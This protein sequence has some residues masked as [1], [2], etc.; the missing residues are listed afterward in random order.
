MKKGLV[1]GL[2]GLFL[3]TGCGKKVTCSQTLKEGGEKI[4][5]KVIADVKK[6]KIDSIEVVYNTESKD[7][8]SKFCKVYKDAKCSGK[9]VTLSNK[10]ALNLFGLTEKQLQDTSK[11]DFVK[12]IESTGFKCK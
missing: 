2:A 7:T 6:D 9:K 10:V 1:L 5:A 12:G 8:A 3:L 11:D 4:E